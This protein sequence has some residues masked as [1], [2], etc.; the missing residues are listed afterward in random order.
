MA[1]RAWVSRNHDRRS[2]RSS[3][4]AIAAAPTARSC[5]RREAFCPFPPRASSKVTTA[6]ALVHC[7]PWRA[8]TSPKVRAATRRW[9][10][11]AAARDAGI[12]D[13]MITT[14]YQRS[15]IPPI[16]REVARMRIAQLNDCAAC[17][18]FRAPSVRTGVPEEHYLHLEEYRTLARLLLIAN[19]LR[20]STPTLCVR[21]PQHR[22][23]AVH[24][25]ARAL[26]ATTIPRPHAVL[27][28]VVG[29]GRTL[30][31]LPGSP[32]T[33]RS[34]CRS[35][36][37]SSLSRFGVRRSS[38]KGSASCW[39]LLRTRGCERR[40]RVRRVHPLPGLVDQQAVRAQACILRLADEGGTLAR[41]PGRE[42][43]SSAA[44]GLG[45]RSRSPTCSPTRPASANGPSTTSIPG[46]RSRTMHSSRR[47]G[48]T[49]CP[50]SPRGA[51]VQR[52]G[53]WTPRPHRRA[54]ERHR[55]TPST[56]P[57]R[58]SIR[59]GCANTFVGNAHRP[60]RDRAWLPRRRSRA[61]L[62]PRH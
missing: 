41:R 35:G 37:W 55:C 52:S 16:E 1:S 9:C 44:P 22:R 10:G 48:T 59:C 26:R 14:A 25:T 46:G 33:A 50:T 20:S 27:R 39:R 17:S 54:G 53:L 36:S 2:R 24:A 21:P 6:S 60:H 3:I 32:T 7:T 31:V 30:E 58:S 11:A 57:R 45:T 43:G 56:S 61:E 23:R 4:S 15:K 51:R 13:R 38:R 18:T 34:T 19:G 28:G 47:Y 49:P 8:S 12:V 42:T 40:G 29:L 5:N 62:G